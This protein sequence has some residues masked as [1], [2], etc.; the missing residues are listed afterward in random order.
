MLMA[1]AYSTTAYSTLGIPLIP[2]VT[3]AAVAET[4]CATVLF[5]DLH[6]YDALVEK[7][8]PCEVLSLL[9]EFFA[10]FT[11]AVLEWG[12]QTF[13]QV[14]ADMM[15]GFGVGDCHHTQI[16]EAIAAARAIQQ[17]FAPI[18]TSWQVRYSIHTGVGIGI[19]RGDVAIGYFGLTEQTLRTLVGDT[20]NVAAHLCKR[21]RV[22]E[23]LL[24]EA[25]YLPHRSF[26]AALGRTEPTPFLH[27]PQLQLRGRSAP[28]DAWCIPVPVRPP[29]QRA[30]P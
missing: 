16:H 11:D 20:A 26:S 14:E 12:G 29:M 10:V 7:L 8:P 22:G 15:A 24:S 23:V 25:V 6:G 17:S 28:L 19:H 18:R 5:A 2:G 1:P 9:E 30:A 13:R 21:A 3:R 4:T 27:L